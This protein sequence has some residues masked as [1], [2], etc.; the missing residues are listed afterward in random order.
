MLQSVTLMGP[1]AGTRAYMDRFAVTNRYGEANE[2]YAFGM[3]M[4]EVR[5]LLANWLGLT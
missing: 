4:L 1:V 2:V 5:C 3:L